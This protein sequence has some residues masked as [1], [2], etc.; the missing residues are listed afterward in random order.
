MT[1]PTTIATS[2]QIHTAEVGR[3]ISMLATRHD[4]RRFAVAIRAMSPEHHDVDAARALGYDD[5]LAPAYFFATISLSLGRVLPSDELRPDGL[6]K[7]DDIGFPVV[8]GGSTVN[9][10]RPIVAGEEIE[11]IERF[12]GSRETSGHSGRLSLLRYKREYFANGQIAVDET[13]VR[14]GRHE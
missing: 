6:A 13:L 2:A 4:I 11:V 14:I 3:T 10:H 1:E 8:A 12:L 5:L 9:W 7:S